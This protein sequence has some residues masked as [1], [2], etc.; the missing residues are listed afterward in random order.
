MPLV[1]CKICERNFYIK[2][3]HQRLGWGKYC[4]RDCQVKSQFNGQL[5]KCFIC[6]QKIYRSKAHLKRSL[7]GKYFCS[8]TCQTLW[9]NQ[10]YSG[11]N[12]THWKTGIRAYR[13]ILQRSDK[14][15]ICTLCKAIDKRI[16][17]VHHIDHNRK[18][19]ILENL[20]WL[21]FNCHFL[22]HHFKES[23]VKLLHLRALA[24]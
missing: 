13:D 5:V 6:E 12:S 19:N 10:V 1:P 14:E 16:L 8:K 4:S 23:E 7:S 24:A 11:E 18:N 2:P 21:C 22:V 17:I 9:R 15:T 3:S 20:T